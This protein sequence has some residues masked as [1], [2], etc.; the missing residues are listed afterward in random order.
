MLFIP[1]PH[2][3]KD[4]RTKWLILP[5]ASVSTG[6]TPAHSG[7][8]CVLRERCLHCPRRSPS[9]PLLHPQMISISWHKASERLNALNRERWRKYV[10]GLLVSVSIRSAWGQRSVPGWQTPLHTLIMKSTESLPQ[11]SNRGVR[12]LP[13]IHRHAPFW[14]L[15]SLEYFYHPSWPLAPQARRAPRTGWRCG[16]FEFRP[17]ECVS[18]LSDL[19]GEIFHAQHC[20]PAPHKNKE[21]VVLFYQTTPLWSSLIFI[22]PLARGKLNFFFHFLLLYISLQTKPARFCRF[23]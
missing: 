14:P 22:V 9:A 6:I 21:V 23:W 20:S 18:M 7:S 17:F 3:R 12:L 16:C 5:L 13:S 11:T 15:S 19:L 10:D 4:R 8:P 2:P 1:L